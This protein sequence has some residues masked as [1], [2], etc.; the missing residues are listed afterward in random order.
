MLRWVFGGCGLFGLISRWW[1]VGGRR[2]GFGRL[3]AAVDVPEVSVGIDD[4]AD[5]FFELF[6][7]CWE[8]DFS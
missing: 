5:E 6:R 8:G 1:R 2:C 3:A 7:F 4:V